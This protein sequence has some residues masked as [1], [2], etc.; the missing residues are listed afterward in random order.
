ME[1]V[2]KCLSFG[3]L[4]LMAREGLSVELSIDRVVQDR[5]EQEVTKMIMEEFSPVSVS[6]IV[7]EPVNW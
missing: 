7:S 6:I 1:G 2:E 5:V 3:R 4:N